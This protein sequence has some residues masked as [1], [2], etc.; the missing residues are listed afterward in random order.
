MHW[1]ESSNGAFSK[2]DILTFAKSNGWKCVDTVSISSGALAKWLVNGK[3][4]FP[5]SYTDF[6]DLDNLE[7][8]FPRWIDP[9]VTV[10]RHTTGWLAV[11]P[12]NAVQTEING[13]IVVSSDSSQFSVYHLWGE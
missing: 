7:L 11:Q 13:Y 4:H 3:A 10:Y 5:F 1:R 2:Y 12:G 9:D 6:S 8:K